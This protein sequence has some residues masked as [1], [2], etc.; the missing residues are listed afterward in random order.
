M[1]KL[2]IFLKKNTITQFILMFVRSIYFLPYK[3]YVRKLGLKI[4]S[5]EESVQ[6][7]ISEKLSVARFGDGEFNLAFQHRGIGFQEYSKELEKQLLDV[8][9]DSK[10]TAVTVALPHG[11]CDTSEDRFKTKVFWWSYVVRNKHNI[12]SFKNSV[13]KKEVLDASFT[14]VITELKNKNKINRIIEKI[15]MIWNAKSVLIV[16]GSGTQFGIGND[17]LANAAHVSRIIAPAEDAYKKVNQIRKEI[18][19]FINSQQS[20]EDVVVLIALGPTATVLAYEF[21]EIV[22]TIDIGHFD[23]QYEYLVNGSYDRIKLNNRY[24]NEMINGASFLPS[25]NK[26]YQS[27]IIALI[28]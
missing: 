24:D 19:N 8:M 27:E 18:R 9:R 17:L 3:L 10:K 23:L 26:K 28:N 1:K 22:Q 12:I 20:L 7:I 13:G 25:Q 4:I 16:E 15:K 2:L 5:P 11:Y 21:G 6:M 14:R